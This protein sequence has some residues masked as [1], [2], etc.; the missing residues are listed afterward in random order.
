AAQLTRLQ[1][2]RG[3][4]LLWSRVNLELR[5]SPKC[6]ASL[7]LWPDSPLLKRK[8]VTLGRWIRR[9]VDVELTPGSRRDVRRDDRQGRAHYHCFGRG[10]LGT[11][12]LLGLQPR[13]ALVAQ[14]R[15]RHRH[16]LLVFR[17]VVRA[18]IEDRAAGARR[19]RRLQYP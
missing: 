8:R 13:H 10:V 18:G 4:G 6:A 14:A 17:A 2:P 19:R 7:P 5:R 11:D 1:K 3:I 16:L 12:A 15:T 9:G